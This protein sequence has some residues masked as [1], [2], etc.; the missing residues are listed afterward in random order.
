M[1]HD[2]QQ[3][4]TKPAI[5]TFLCLLMMAP[6]VFAGP[7]DGWYVSGR[8]GFSS[9]SE[10]DYNPSENASFNR[11]SVANN[12]GA[13]VGYQQGHVRYEGEYMG[14]YG[15]RESGGG[16]FIPLRSSGK[17]TTH[18]VMGNVYYDLF[19]DSHLEKRF[20]FSP[21]VGVGLGYAHNTRDFNQTFLDITL[22]DESITSN[23]FA[24]QAM[25]GVRMYV[26][27]KI[28]IAPEY[29]YFATTKLN[30]SDDNLSSNSFFLNLSY[31]FGA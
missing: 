9:F 22:A 8:L 5:L 27:Q 15:L 14:M 1:K 26:S 16:L 28:S 30:N 12:I 18:A 7:S 4:I 29:R 21:Y 19:S 6:S 17:L 11:S 24:Y 25:I 2:K 20:S 13:G 10:I 31:Q 3:M 23:L